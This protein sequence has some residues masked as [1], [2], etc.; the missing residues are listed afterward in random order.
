M[1]HTKTPFRK[2]AIAVI[3]LLNRFICTLGK[4]NNPALMRIVSVLF[5]GSVSGPQCGFETLEFLGYKVWLFLHCV[6]RL[7]AGVGSKHIANGR[8]TSRTRQNRRRQVGSVSAP[9]A[10]GLKIRGMSGSRVSQT[11]IRL[12]LHFLPAEIAV[13]AH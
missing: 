2:K 4:R 6:S 9:I 3:N 12:E 10:R 8:G 1:I 11:P 5:F 13:S 7:L